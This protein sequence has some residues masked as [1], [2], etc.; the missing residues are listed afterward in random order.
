MRYERLEFFPQLVL[1]NPP[2]ERLSR[3]K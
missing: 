2:F 3:Q 1:I